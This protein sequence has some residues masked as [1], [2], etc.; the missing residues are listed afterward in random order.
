MRERLRSIEGIYTKPKHVVGLRKSFVRSLLSSGTST[1]IDFLISV[2]CA[3]GF[4]VYYVTATTIGGLFGATT[5]FFIG[6]HW[7]FKKRNGK[8]KHQ[9]VRFLFT[10]V[11]SIF[12]NTSGVFF[13]KEH[14]QLPFVTSR[15]IV[16]VFVGV[17]FNFLMNRYFVFRS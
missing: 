3:V 11:F 10:N 4:E 12:L 9:L 16:S 15:I 1:S 8:I 6:R 2:I 5:S 7:V 14:F 17:C 13:V